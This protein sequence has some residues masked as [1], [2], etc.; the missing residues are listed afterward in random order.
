MDSLQEYEASFPGIE[1]GF[2]DLFVALTENQYDTAEAQ[3]GS[4]PAP[5]DLSVDSALQKARGLEELKSQNANDP[6]FDEWSYKTVQYEEGSEPLGGVFGNGDLGV[7]SS[8]VDAIVAALSNLSPGTGSEYQSYFVSLSEALARLEVDSTGLQDPDVIY[9]DLKT[10]FTTA[11]SDAAAFGALFLDASSFVA[12]YQALLEAFEQIERL[13][14]VEREQMR[15]TFRAE[16]D[17]IKDEISLERSIADFE[18]KMDAQTGKVF[19]DIHGNRVRT[20]EYIFRPAVDSVQILSLTLR[21]GGEN[22]GISSASFG[23]QFNRD[24]PAD[25]KSLPWDDYMNVVTAEDLSQKLAPGQDDPGYDQYIVYESV[26]EPVYYPTSIYAE[27]RN[28]QNDRVDSDTLRFTE[29]YDAPATVTLLASAAEG[30]GGQAYPVQGRASE[31]TRIDPVVGSTVEFRREFVP[32][33]NHKSAFY[34]ETLRVDESNISS[35]HLEVIENGQSQ[36]TPS[37]FTN[38]LTVVKGFRTDIYSLTGIFVP[39]D[40]EGNAIDAPGFRIRGIRDL[41]SPNPLVNEG[42]YNLEA[43]FFYEQTNI[44]DSPNDPTILRNSFNIDVIITPEIFIDYGRLTVQEN[45]ARLFGRSLDESSE[46]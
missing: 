36:E 28:P 14:E 12:D 30:E 23:F 10:L 11:E 39:F 24:L 38:E 33:A 13:R 15:D 46:V 1:S 4:L 44:S 7:V 41:L 6:D 31:T 42:N 37:S 8:D 22:R 3:L 26:S 5:E 9:Q 25:L 43:M 17:R 45:Q 18:K 2:Q 40:N 34:D 32:A 19:T 16:I 29:T 21:A 27:F 20:D 35:P